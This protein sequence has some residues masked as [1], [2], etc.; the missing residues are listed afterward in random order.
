VQAALNRVSKDRTTIMIA[1]RLSTVRN[2]DRI[3]VLRDGENVEEEGVYSGLVKA[4]LLGTFY[5]ADGFEDSEHNEWAAS[6]EKNEG[7]LNSIPEEAPAKKMGGFMSLSAILYEQR[8]YWMLYIVILAAAAGSGCKSAL[9]VRRKLTSHSRL[10]S[11]KLPL[12]E[13]D[14]GLQ[15]HRSE[16]DRCRQLLGIDVLRPSPSCGSLLLYTRVLLCHCLAC[17]SPTCDLPLSSSLYSLLHP[18][19]EK[20]TS[21]ASSENRSPSSTLLPTA[22]EP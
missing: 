3:I 16:A 2:A 8:A 10:R 14:R 18:S 1:H 9:F 4:Q 22:A 13:T 20:T 19:T 5:G 6:E 7:E 15:F 12:C 11:P 21:R 17:T